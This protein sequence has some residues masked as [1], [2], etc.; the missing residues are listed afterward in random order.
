MSPKHCGPRRKLRTR[1]TILP[2]N[3]ARTARPSK[4]RGKLL[5][6]DNL[7]L[8]VRAVVRFLIL[9][10]PPKLRRVPETIPLH[11]VIRH[12]HH[13][14]GPKG[15]PGQILAL[16]PSALAARHSMPGLLGCGFRRSP[17]FPGMTGQGIFPIGLEK[18]D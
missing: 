4:D 3:G 9:T 1:T 16:A 11:V 14:L 13:K 2:G 5:R 6:W 17:V 18:I 12:F 10:P 7:K 15:L 8:R